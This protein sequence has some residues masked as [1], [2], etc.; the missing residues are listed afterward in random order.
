MR[1]AADRLLLFKRWPANWYEVANAAGG[2]V[3]IFAENSRR[4]K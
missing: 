3:Q 1:L 4:K 2:H